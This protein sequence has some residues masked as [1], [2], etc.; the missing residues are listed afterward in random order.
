[1]KPFDLDKALSG[2]KLITRSGGEVTRFQK[3]QIRGL[4]RHF[5]QLYPY[6]AEVNGET[7]YFTENG[8]FIDELIISSSDLF[9]AE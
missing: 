9:L 2:A 1:M 7:M 5:P 6:Q 4:I 3:S 8:Y